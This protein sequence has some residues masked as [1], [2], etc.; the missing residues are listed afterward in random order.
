MATHR[1]THLKTVVGRNIVDAREKKGWTQLDLAT[2]LGT[3]I[4][5]VSGWE[6]GK[7]LPRNPQAVADH[8]L[9]GE[10]G[11]L[12]TVEGPKEAAA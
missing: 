5:R 10:V 4:S 8:L 9:D 1:T 2:A 3:S 11:R 6:N 7:H 12:F